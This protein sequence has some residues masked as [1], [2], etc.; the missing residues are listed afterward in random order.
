[1]TTLIQTL[2]KAELHLHIEGT[3]EPNLVF[4][5]AKRNH[6][7]LPFSSISELQKA[8]HFHDLQSFL[9]LYYQCMQVL[10]EEQD[11]YDLTWDYMQKAKDNHIL[12]AEIFCDP[13]AH[14][15]RGVP[16]GNVIKGIHRACVDAKNQLNIT[17][18]IIPCILR[19]QSVESAHKTL[20]QLLQYKDI[21][22]GLGL[23]SAEKDHPPEKFVAVFAKAR[24]HGLVTVAH[25]GEEG[26][27]DYIWQALNLLKVKRI[28]HGVRATEDETLIQ[29]LI[30]HKIPLTMCP[31]SNIKLCVYDNLSQHPL[32]QLLDKGVCVTVN[33]DDPAYFGGYIN[34]N[35]LAS[36]SAL[37]LTEKDLYQ[38]CINSFNASFIDDELR[39]TYLAQL[40]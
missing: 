18:H 30:Q 2:P 4:A 34:D 11:F 8:Y 38:L 24:E 28:D 33:S 19:D 13:Q 1:M 29:Y 7:K 17:S 22:K 21:I 31:L 5:L 36:A 9:D 3:F 25:A 37:N 40:K 15:S 12:H 35:F 6:I 32:K 16:L 27:A 10:H 39:Q 20:D 23:C 26:P 14:T